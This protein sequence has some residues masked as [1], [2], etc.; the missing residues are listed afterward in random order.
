[1]SPQIRQI[2][3]ELNEQKIY[4]RNHSLMGNYLY[5]DHENLK[6]KV[7]RF[8]DIISQPKTKIADT[9]SA[10]I[11][12]SN[13][14][15]SY[16]DDIDTGIISYD[17][18]DEIVG[19]PRIHNLFG[20]IDDDAGNFGASPGISPV[21]DEEEG[22]WHDKGDIESDNDE[23]KKGNLTMLENELINDFNN[24]NKKVSSGEY[25]EEEPT[26]IKTNID[27]TEEKKPISV[28]VKEIEKNSYD[29]WKEGEAEKLRIIQEKKERKERIKLE[30][31]RL[32]EEEEKE[33][34]ED[35]R[36]QS[37]AFAVQ[38]Q[39]VAM[40]EKNKKSKRNDSNIF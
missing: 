21:I 33:L 14:K 16:D 23:E 18:D 34:Q 25:I 7:N 39:N 15:K 22:I 27:L 4:N 37:E 13:Y 1:M 12:E 11:D 2:Q 32:K 40:Q 29:I 5:Y 17:S 38:Q 36:I 20:N 9:T 24:F 3:N 28:N 19:T 6:N 30:K 26:P 35:I 8:D 10:Y 31:Q